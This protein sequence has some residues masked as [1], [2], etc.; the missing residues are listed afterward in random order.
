MGCFSHVDSVQVEVTG[1]IVVDSVV[2]L[3]YVVNDSTIYEGEEFVLVAY[4]T[5]SILPGATYNW[6]VDNLLVSTTN[7]TI[8]E[9]LNAIEIFGA[10]VKGF[11]NVPIRVEIVTQDGCTKLDTNNMQVHNIPIGIPNAF[12]PNGDS[13]NDSF[14]V[15]S[16]IPLTIDEF[17]V[18]NRWGQLVYDNENGPDGWNGKQNNEDAPSDV[19]IYRVIYQITGGSGKQYI[20][21]GDVTLLR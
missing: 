14:R 8:S 1:A 18:W 6:Y 17:K 9:V 13:K 10:D 21:K 12:S 2:A 7:D 15:V 3:E 4:T 20:K 5:P 19:Y 11:E 16:L